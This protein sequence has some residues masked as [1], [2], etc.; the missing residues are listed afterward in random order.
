MAMDRDRILVIGPN[1]GL[2]NTK[3]FSL[4]TNLDELNI[5]IW[6]P[7]TLY[8]EWSENSKGFNPQT[9]VQTFQERIGHLVKWVQLGHCLCI[10]GLWPYIDLKYQIRGEPFTYKP[11]LEEPFLG[12]AFEQTEG[13]LVE[14][15][16]IA[17]FPPGFANFIISMKYQGLLKGSELIPLF[18]VYE[19]RDQILDRRGGSGGGSAAGYKKFGIVG[20]YK[21]LDA[22]IVMFLPTVNVTELTSV[23][24]T[25]DDYHL[26][27]FALSQNLPLTPMEVLQQVERDNKRIEELGQQIRKALS[28]R[29]KS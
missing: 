7:V 29:P 26:S 9:R 17:E 18:R 27:L 1:Q 12:I 14:F 10:V 4:N 5:V 19:G 13:D 8:Q 11:L 23:G 6:H 20:G 24:I 15:C 25:W 28:Q 21:K 2:R 3:L 16:G 22:G